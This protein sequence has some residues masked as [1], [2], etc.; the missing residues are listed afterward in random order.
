MCGVCAP[1]ADGRV[2]SVPAQSITTASRPTQANLTAPTF[3]RLNHWDSSKALAGGRP[4][5]MGS[6][7]RTA[8]EDF[9]ARRLEFTDDWVVNEVVNDDGL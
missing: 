1:P 2:E 4:R 9:G 5:R 8:D 3:T 6:G 7:G